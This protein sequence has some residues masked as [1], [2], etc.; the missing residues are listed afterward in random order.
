MTLDVSQKIG[1]I[2]EDTSI[3]KSSVFSSRKTRTI[4]SIQLRKRIGSKLS[5]IRSIVK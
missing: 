2:G 5:V 4:S 1:C 3:T